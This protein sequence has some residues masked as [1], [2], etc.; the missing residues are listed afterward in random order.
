[1]IE[2]NQTNEISQKKRKQS[3]LGIIL[4]IIG[5]IWFAKESGVTFPDWMFGF[6][7][8]FFLIGIYQLFKNGLNQIGAYVWIF[9]SFAFM[10]EHF[11]SWEF[12]PYFLPLILVV[13]G[14]TLIFNPIRGWRKRNSTNDSIGQNK[15]KY[16]IDNG[17][18]IQVFMGGVQKTITSNEFHGGTI[19]CFMGGVEVFFTN[20]TFQECPIIEIS[21]T[22][23]GVELYLPANWEIK[24]NLSVYLGGVKDNRNKSKIESTSK[25]YIQLKGTIIMGGV[26]IKDILLVK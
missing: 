14:I 26:E 10:L 13:L 2:T 18:S 11:L 3:A 17:V 20:S 15:D 23:G 1:M 4:L 8:V 25:K 16:S 24:N 6:H 7:S 5:G 19:N 22:M 21:N 9:I 12:R